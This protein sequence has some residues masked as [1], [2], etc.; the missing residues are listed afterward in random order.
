MR[1]KKIVLILVIVLII[2]TSCTKKPSKQKELLI[3]C[4]ITMVKPM[5]EIKLLIE[6]EY[7]CKILISKGGSGN[8]LSSLKSNKIGDLYLPGD[9]SYIE[10]CWE[11]NLISDTIFVGY[12]KA[13]IM[14]QK[15]NPKNISSDLNNLLNKDYRVVMGNPESSAIGR[16]TK[17]MLTKK[18]IFDEVMKNVLLLTTDGKKMLRVLKEK[19]ADLIISWS[20]FAKWEEH[21]DYVTEIE[22][23]EKYAKKKKL[24]IGLLKTSKYPEISKKFMELAG[25]KRGKE[26]FHKYGLGN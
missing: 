2:I 14:V 1:K 10:K 18:G 7:D 25:S 13:A 11:Q 21:K 15:G 19:K 9:D 17:K 23:D 5:S 12:N 4:G 24:V 16:I 6:K 20:A 8:L 3:Y 26:I 22:I